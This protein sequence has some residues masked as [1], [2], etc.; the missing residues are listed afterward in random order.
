MRLALGQFAV[1][2]DVAVLA[3]DD[4]VDRLLGVAEV[5]QAAL[6]RGVDPGEAAR[7]E[8]LRGA[9]AE[10]DRDAAGVDEVELLLLVVEVAAGRVA[11]AA[12]RSR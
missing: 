1:A 9:V 2:A 5:A 6:G 10:L 4:H 8:L 12:A 7:P 11:R 3:A